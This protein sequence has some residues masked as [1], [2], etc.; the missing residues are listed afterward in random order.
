[1]FTRNGVVVLGIAALAAGLV[2]SAEAQV[3]GRVVFADG[4]IG[5]SVVFGDRPARVVVPRRVVRRSAVPARYRRGMSLYELDLYLARI[6][7]EYDYYRRMHHRDAYYTLGWTKHELRAYVRWLRDER[8]LLR[9]ERRRLE[10][11]G[12]GWER[13]RDRRGRRW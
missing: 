1:M 13:D 8:R 12:R 9:D 10:R 5:V 7:S 4:P 2:E 11:A 3:S 6:D